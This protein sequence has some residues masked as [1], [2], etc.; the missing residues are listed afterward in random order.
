FSSGWA[1]AA[2]GIDPGCLLAS[3]ES[4]GTRFL[5]RG[6]PGYPTLLSAIEDPPLGLFCRGKPPPGD[7]SL[8]AVVGARKASPYGLEVARWLSAELAQAGVGIVSGAAYGIDSA[9]HASA[10]D[11]GGYSCAV[12]G[13]GIDVVY[14]RSQAGLYRRLEAAGCILSEYPPGVHPAKER[15]PARNRIIA[16][17]TPGVVVV[18]A[19]GSS[20]A[21][22]TARFALDGGREVMAVPGQVLSDNSAGTNALIR[23]GAVAITRPEDV[24][25]A[26]G[27][28]R[29]FKPDRT[30]GERMAPAGPEQAALLRALERGFCDVEDLARIVGLSAGRALSLL[31][32]MEV[33]GLVTRGRGSRYQVG[34]R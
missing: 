8:A 15:F 13:C 26:L 33:E 20:G 29:L 5:A 32:A 4:G 16:G 1:S 17:M 7:A 12:L 19:S 10:L 2:R 22:I 34:P 28:D 24:L 18:E 11:A 9:A 27:L 23:E 6:E 14:P 30:A 21:L 25:D 3:L 31:A